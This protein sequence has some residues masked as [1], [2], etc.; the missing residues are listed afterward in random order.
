MKITLGS[1]YVKAVQYWRSNPTWL[2]A[3]A[4]AIEQSANRADRC[5]WVDIK[6]NVTAHERHSESYRSHNGAFQLLVIR[7]DEGQPERSF[8]VNIDQD[9]VID[10]KPL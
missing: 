6:V 7:Q 3:L 5:G 8:Y 10:L 4:D 2:G 1:D 9:G